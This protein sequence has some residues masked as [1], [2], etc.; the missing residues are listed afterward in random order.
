MPPQGT[1]S[2][3]GSRSADG[4]IDSLD[5]SSSGGDGSNRNTNNNDNSNNNNNNNNNNGRGRNMSD[6]SNA[7][8]K[9]KGG[10]FAALERQF[11]QPAA[12]RRSGISEGLGK[13]APSPSQR[14]RMQQENL[15]M[16]CGLLAHM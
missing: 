1:G 6:S 11:S 10:D 13:G 9:G 12:P 4:G 7:D 14:L 5:G 15:D 8:G 16:R 3:G 2:G